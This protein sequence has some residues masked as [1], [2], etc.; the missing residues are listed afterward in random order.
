MIINGF[1]VVVESGM[2]FGGRSFDCV[3]REAKNKHL[4]AERP[5]RPEVMI[6]EF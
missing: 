1:R 5:S 2:T 3:P 6:W 4:G